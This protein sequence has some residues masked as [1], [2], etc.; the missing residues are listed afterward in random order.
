MGVVRQSAEPAGKTRRVDHVPVAAQLLPVGSGVTQP[1]PAGVERADLEPHARRLF[2]ITLERLLVDLFVDVA[3]PV[4]PLDR[5]PPRQLVLWIPVT[6]ADS[7]VLRRDV[8][9]LGVAAEDQ[10]NVCV[11]DTLA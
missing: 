3:E 6:P 7:R 2:D 1:E 9:E 4:V 10:R 5:E 11:L 8:I